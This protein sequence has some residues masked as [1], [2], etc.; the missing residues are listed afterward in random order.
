MPSKSLAPDTSTYY[1]VILACKKGGKW[2]RCVELLRE[3]QSKDIEQDA[4]IYK[5]VIAACGRVKHITL[6]HDLYK[7]QIKRKIFF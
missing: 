2:K 1:N 4:L 7:E 5:T 3:M 6:M